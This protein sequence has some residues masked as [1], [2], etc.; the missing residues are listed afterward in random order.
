VEDMKFFKTFFTPQYLFQVNSAFIS[1]AEKLFFLAGGIL[2]LLAAVLKIASVL[3]LNPVDR[4]YR[5]K[6]YRL[7]LSIGIS[8]LIWYLCRFENVTFFDTRF[9]EWLI[10]L[11]AII[12]FVVIVVKTIK[13]YGKEKNAWDKEQVRLKYLP[14]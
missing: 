10:V 7:F 11:L 4:A 6:F 14:K 1:P 5:Q 3:A 2:V 13:N 9:V 8:A 12:W